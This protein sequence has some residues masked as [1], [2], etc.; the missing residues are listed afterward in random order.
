[1]IRLRHDDAPGDIVGSKTPMQTRSKIRLDTIEQIKRTLEALPQHHDEEV[2]KK[3]AI[4]I[5][6]PNIEAIRS[7]GYGLPAI[8][9]FL[10]G[11]GIPITVPYLKTVISPSRHD[12]EGKKQRKRK[13]RQRLRETP[14]RDTPGDSQNSERSKGPAEERTAGNTKVDASKKSPAGPKKD[15]QGA[16]REVRAGAPVAPPERRSMFVPREDSEEI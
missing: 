13:D 8:A 2:T 7:K 14:A 9:S 11:H 5:L 6:L 12:A 10:S 16:Q 3:Q 1:M 4:R 15:A